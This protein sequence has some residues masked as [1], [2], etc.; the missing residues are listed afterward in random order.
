M[1]EANKMSVNHVSAS[2]QKNRFKS[3]QSV[4]SVY[5]QATQPTHNPLS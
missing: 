3:V 1:S 2:E 5:Y 4:K